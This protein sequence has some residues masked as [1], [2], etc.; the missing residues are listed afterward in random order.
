MTGFTAT[1]EQAVVIVHGDE[2]LRVAAGAGTGKT[3]TIAHRL[4]R[5]VEAGTDPAR[6]L[7]VTFTNKAADELR[8]RLREAIAARSDGRE[9]E[10]ATYH[11]FASGILDEFGGRIGYQRGAMLMDEGHRSEL[12]ARVLRSLPDTSLDLTALSHRR[13]ELL[14]VPRP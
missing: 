1:P 11:S 10:V 2:P 5:A 7:G 14:T 9:L 13:D 4:A 12:A 3:T 6:A 8:S